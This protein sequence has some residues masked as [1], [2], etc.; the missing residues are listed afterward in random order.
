MELCKRIQQTLVLR[1]ESETDLVIANK[2]SPLSF[3]NARLLCATKLK[4]MQGAPP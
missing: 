3:G 2:A 1:K 4:K